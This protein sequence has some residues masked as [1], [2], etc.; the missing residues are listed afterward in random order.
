MR[1][2]VLALMLA[3]L[4]IAPASAQ[5]PPYGPEDVIP[6]AEKRQ[7]SAMLDV[8]RG[9]ERVEALPVKTE[10]MALVGHVVEEPMPVDPVTGRALGKLIA[11]YDWTRWSAMGCMFQPAVAF[12][13]RRGND[14]T[15]VEVCFECG[16]MALSGMAGRFGDRKLLDSGERKAFLRAAKKAFPDRFA[17]LKE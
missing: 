15:M 7:L 17:D 2:A 11:R 14:S 4:S 5:G 8:V 9:A 6:E 13:F 1:S 12:R 16:E 10:D 3:G